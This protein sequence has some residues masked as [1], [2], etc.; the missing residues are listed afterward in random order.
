MPPNVPQVSLVE[1]LSAEQWQTLERVHAGN[2]FA[3]HRIRCH[4]SDPFALVVAK[5]EDEGGHGL[6]AVARWGQWPQSSPFAVEFQEGMC[7]L[8][9][10]SI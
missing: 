2:V 10:T 9:D 5:P 8:R 6:V 3:R 1:G 4:I 7:P